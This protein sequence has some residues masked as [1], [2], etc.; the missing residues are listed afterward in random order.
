MIKITIDGI[1][2]EVPENM[3]VLEAART[4]GIDIPTLC[5]LKDINEVGDCRMCL[6]EVEGARGFVPSCMQ[7]VAD[8][9]VV[10]TN[11]NEVNEARKNVLELILS[12]H[13]KKCLSCI[14]NGNCELQDLAQKFGITDVEFEGAINNKQIDDK[15]TSIVRNTAKCVLCRRCTSTC[16]KVQEIGAIECMN[17]GFDSSISTVGNKSLADVNCTFCGQ[18][19]QNCPTAAL[20]EKENIDEVWEKLKDENAVVLVQTAPAVRVALGEE[21]GMPIG[22]NVAGKMVTA[23]KRLGFNKVFDTN[24]GAD[25]TIMEEASEFINRVLNADDKKPLPMLTSCCPAWI[26]FIEMEYP[27]Y[28]ANLSSCKSPHEM[29]GAILKTYYAEKNNIDPKN[30]YVVSVMPCVAKKF[31]RQ[32]PEMQNEDLYNV[33]AVITTRELAKMIR[34]ANIDFEDL[35][36]SGFDNP[37]G[38][39]TGAGAIFGTTGGVMEAALRT[40]QDLLTGKDLEEIKFEDVRGEKGIKRA[41]VNVN[42]KDIRIIVAS[43]LGNARKVMEMVKAGTAEADFIEVM[44]CPGGCIMGGGQPIKSSKTRRKYDVRKLRA[45]A[46][47]TIDEK[48]TIRK[49][50]QNPVLQEV[51]KDF[52]GEPNGH[53]AHELLHTSYAKREKY[54]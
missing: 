12:A 38:E 26:R 4:V 8:G 27:E 11:T 36:D 50:H 7:K 54:L 39:A 10:R 51:Y 37:M 47:Y 34:Q 41:T 23:L 5:F 48:S 2:T 44:A 6:V 22:T 19:I 46:L 45:D 33:D 52:F 49:S 35:T 53:K 3:T 13:E 15:S 32:R 40:A 20:H 30:I 28:L 29:F 18:C 42:G 21:F 17:R 24:T 1:E 9:M 43:G 16:Q 31:E 14:R 25:F